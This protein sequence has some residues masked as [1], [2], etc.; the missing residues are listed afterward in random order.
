MSEDKERLD[1]A[2]KKASNRIQK[3]IAAGSK[4]KEKPPS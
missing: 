4:I 3:L 2:V 1:E